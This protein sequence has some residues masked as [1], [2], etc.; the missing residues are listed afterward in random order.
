MHLLTLRKSYE[1]KVEMETFEG[2]K[3]FVLYS[4]FSVGPELDGYKLSLDGFT[5]GGAGESQ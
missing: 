5:D 1:L 2:A 3:A 4:S